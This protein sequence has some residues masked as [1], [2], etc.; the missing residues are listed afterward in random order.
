MKNFDH[1]RFALLL[2]HDVIQHSR[3]YLRFALGSF[4]AF[5][6]INFLLTYNSALLQPKAD[7]AAA[8]NW[9]LNNVSDFS[10]FI[11]VLLIIVSVSSIFG[12]MNTKQERI[13]FLMLPATNLEK[14]LCRWLQFS[15]LSVILIVATYCLADVA[16]WLL[17][18]MM[19]QGLG[20]SMP[21]FFSGTTRALLFHADWTEAAGTTYEFNPVGLI[22]LIAFLSTYHLGGAFFRRVPF[23]FTTLA[24]IASGIA[25]T[26]VMTTLATIVFDATNIN[27]FFD[28]LDRSSAVLAFVIFYVL[29]IAWAALCHW[30]AYRMFCRANVITHKTIGL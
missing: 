11:M 17:R 26:I 27:A 5:F 29:P 1:N 10:T 6:I 2:K 12:N 25:L 7:I 21:R 23:I 18:T 4:V 9:D 15:F 16:C 20:L 3:T 30:S 28:M 19:G 13:R 14:Y 8:A 24:I 22:T